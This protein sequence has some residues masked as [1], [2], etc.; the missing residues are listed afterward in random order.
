MKLSALKYIVIACIIAVATIVLNTF[1]GKGETYSPRDYDEIASSGVLRAVTEYSSIS[2][3]VVGDTVEGFDYELLQAFASGKGLRLEITPEMSYEKRLL[4]V[5]S[6]QYDILACATA[7][8]AQHRDS[9]LFTVPLNRSCLV[10]VQRTLE[11]QTDSLF[12]RNQLSLA[13]LTIHI[14][15]ESPSRLRLRNI[16][17]EIADTIYIEEIEYYGS[18]QLLAMVSAGDIDYA[19]CDQTTASSL[20]DKF[21]NLDIGTEIGFTQ[22]YAWAVNKKSVALLDSLNSFL[23]EKLAEDAM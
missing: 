3:H 23:K 20:I 21:P 13:G 11:E 5:C 10:L 15:K 14:V 12:I 19:V 17:N 6:G 8:T 4:G 7:I 18:E 22:L 9:L 2:Y 16:M 1:L